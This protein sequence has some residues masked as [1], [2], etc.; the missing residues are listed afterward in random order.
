MNPHR[1]RYLTFAA[2]CLVAAC[3]TA[4]EAPVNDAT[5]TLE[6]QQTLALGDTITL[7]YER[8]DD[9]RCPLDARCVWAGN[10]IYHFTLAGKTASEPFMLDIDKPV[11]ESKALKGVRIVLATTEP[12]PVRLS[13]Q[14]PPPHPV[15]ISV[16]NT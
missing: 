12:P 10:I 6:P 15:T 4:S 5:L 8:A 1:A 13:S 9:S 3:T 7:R 16:T 2:A 14:T 11:F